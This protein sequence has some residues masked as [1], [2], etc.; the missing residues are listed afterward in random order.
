MVGARQEPNPGCQ[1]KPPDTILVVEDEVLVRMVI[2]DNLRNAGYKVIEA[3][4]AHEA[5]DL[6]RNSVDVRLILSDVLMPGTM[7]G[8]ALARTVRSEFPLIKI[9]L[10]SGNLTR[11]NWAEYDAFFPKPYDAAQIIKHIKTLLD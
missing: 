7:D 5:L 1:S 10:T 3:S 8:V 9:V 11:P 4:N 6:L 2:A